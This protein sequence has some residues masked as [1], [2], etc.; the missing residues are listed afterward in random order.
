[1]KYLRAAVLAAGLATLGFLLWR[2]DAGTVWKLIAQVG[3]GIVP[4]LIFQ[5]CDHVLNAFGWRFAFSRQDAP[6]VPFWRLVKVRMAGDGVNYL[7]PSGQIAGE[8]VRPAL[9]GD[10]RPEDVKNSSVLVAKFAQALAQAVFIL[11][12]LL[13]VGLYKMNILDGRELVLSI[14]GALLVVALVSLAIYAVS[15]E[16]GW[17]SR[18]FVSRPEIAAMRER[19]R[20]YLRRHPG[21]FMLSTLCFTFGYAWGMLEVMLIL[22]F[23]GV[24]IE[25]IQALAVET[26]SNVVDALM[27]MVPA[28]VG[29]Q[30]AGKVAIFKALGFPAATGL[31]LGL[32]RHL[33]ELLWASAGFLIY[34]LN[35]PADGASAPIRSLLAKEPLERGR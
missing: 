5:I 20:A 22:H 23:M 25:P 16:S 9:L 3:W 6:H 33:R 21:R 31:A 7:T 28:K 34:A 2:L 11:V 10:C 26:L 17:W 29:T 13:F 1:M 24:P 18:R 8:L 32:I 12:G 15:A 19:M 35:R 4:I 14:G 27:F 30:E